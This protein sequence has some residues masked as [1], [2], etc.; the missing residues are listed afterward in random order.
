MTP[1]EIA[2]L[3]KSMIRNY[4]VGQKVRALEPL[5][6]SPSGESPGGLYARQ[7]EILVV[8]SIDANST[9]PITVSHENIVDSSFCVAVN[10]IEV[11]DKN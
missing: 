8:R 9:L 1:N 3:H 2:A 4:A 5:G 11:I 6:D 7:G 10:E